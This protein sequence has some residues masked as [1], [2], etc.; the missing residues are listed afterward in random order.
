VRDATTVAIDKALQARDERAAEIVK[1]R[2]ADRIFDVDS[3]LRA[4]L[5][6]A[7]MEDD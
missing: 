5:A 6:T 2:Y 7:I 3:I 1:T 4:E